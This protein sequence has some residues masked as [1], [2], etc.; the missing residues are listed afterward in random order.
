MGRTRIP[1]TYDCHASQFQVY[2]AEEWNLTVIDI[3]GC[4]VRLPVAAAMAVQRAEALFDFEPT[5]DVELELK[6]CSRFSSI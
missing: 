1:S 4:T 2:T 6:V 3:A 5:A